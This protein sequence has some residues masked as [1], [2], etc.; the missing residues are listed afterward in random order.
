M[1]LITVA[2]LVCNRFITLGASRVD[3]FSCSDSIFCTRITLFWNSL[4]PDASP[5]AFVSTLDH[6]LIILESY[7][8]R[9]VWVV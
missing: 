5:R 8:S 2:A 4:P 1:I 6:R 7:I 9:W 3:F